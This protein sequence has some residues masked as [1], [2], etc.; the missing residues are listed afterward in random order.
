[1]TLRP[2]NCTAEKDRRPRVGIICDLS[3]EHWRSMDLVAEMLLT[4][5]RNAFDSRATTVRLQPSF[6]NRLSLVPGM[7]HSRIAHNAD[8]LINRFWYFPRRLA[9]S[10]HGLDAF[11]I[12]D[13]TYAHLAHWLPQRR[14]IVTCHDL[15][16]IRCIIDPAAAPRSILFRQMA[17]W[18]LSGLKKAEL[19]AC[20]S[21]STREELVGREI[22]PAQ[23]AV[24]V[25]NGVD[26]V[27]SPACDPAADRQATALIGA[28][29]KGAVDVLH[30]GSTIPRK[31]ID[32]L[33]RTFASVHQAHRGARLIRVGGPFDGPQSDLI[34]QY[35]LAQ[36][37]L[38]LP[39]LD[40]RT[41]AAVYRRAT[42]LVLPSEGE[43]FGLP[44]IEAMACGTPVIASDL[45]ALREVGGDAAVYCPV[46]NVPRWTSAMFAMI[47]ERRG[48]EDG[49]VRSHRGLTQAAKFSWER[50]AAA[51][52]ELY[53]RV[54]FSKS[55]PAA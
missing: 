1:M 18:I 21:S 40:R 7:R 12:I 43:G 26:S 36:S 10:V 8:R 31:R 45:P 24:V 16:A 47:A 51:M 46:G 20:V 38:V 2:S 44:V 25:H 14:V 6:V 37:V 23:R 19:V 54:A 32:V 33:L 49:C 48:G 53:R 9:P 15:D 29:V 52:V 13:H 55:E 28:P 50:H 35:D 11:H 3:E 34:R 41:L 22:V 30:V 42:M 5:L 27:F 4:H 39:F 17:R